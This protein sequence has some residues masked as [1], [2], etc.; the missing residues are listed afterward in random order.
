[1]S[2]WRPFM[3]PPSRGREMR[4]I[5]YARQEESLAF[6]ERVPAATHPARPIGAMLHHD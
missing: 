2:W 3:A 5:M 1:M 4:E 6:R